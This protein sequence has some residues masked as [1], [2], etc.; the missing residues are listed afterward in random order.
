MS[1][2]TDTGA[3]A[4]TQNVILFGGSK[5]GTGKSTACANI[6]VIRQKRLLAHG[7]NGL[8][9]VL[10]TDKQATLND[11]NDTRD[12]AGIQ[13]H[14]NVV[15]KID[16]EVKPTVDYWLKSAGVNDVLIDAGGREN[17]GLRSAMLCATKMITPIQASQFDLWTLEKLQEMHS[18]VKSFNPGLQIYILINRASTH[19]FD[20]DAENAR[21]FAKDYPE[22]TLMETVLHDRAIYRRAASTGL[23][24]V[25]MPNAAPK[26][27]SEIMSLYE[28]I[29]NDDI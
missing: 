16:S 19:V 10:D 1:K 22:F 15:Q 7:G 9:Q 5:G 23:S 27:K 4:V 8:L 13:P 14:I 21:D 25:E 12:L 29:F 24:V 6:A 11:W 20:K 28:E 18:D 3:P 17:K 2:D 26:A